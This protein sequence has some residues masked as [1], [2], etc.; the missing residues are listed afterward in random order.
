MMLL[1]LCKTL[2]DGYY[3]DMMVDIRYAYMV[4]VMTVSRCSTRE[5]FNH[6]CH[7]V[8]CCNVN[9]NVMWRHCLWVCT[10]FLVAMHTRT[11][12]QHTH[13]HTRHT[14]QKHIQHTHTHTR[15][16]NISTIYSYR[17]LLLAM[18]WYQRM[19]FVRLQILVSLVR[20]LIMPMM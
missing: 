17:I 8:L 7:L 3:N 16:I 18:C 5:I 20:L 15:T 4:N 19:R 13:T 12:T 2:V 1:L 9:G 10:E 14:K 6:Y 11:H